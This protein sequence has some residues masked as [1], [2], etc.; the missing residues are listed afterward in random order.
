M[1]WLKSVHKLQV[2]QRRYVQTIP[3]H[4]CFCSFDRNA[5][6]LMMM[7]TM[8]MI[9]D[10]NDDSNVICLGSSATFRPTSSD[11]S[12]V[13]TPSKKLAIFNDYYY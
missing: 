12:D 5:N 4:L 6:L 13:E 8:M 1:S 2:D 10:D 11:F 9:N 3:K 7:I